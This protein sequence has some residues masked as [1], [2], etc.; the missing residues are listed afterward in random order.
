[1][2][3]WPPTS[4]AANSTTAVSLMMSPHLTRFLRRLTEAAVH[5]LDEVVRRPESARGAVAALVVADRPR[6]LEL[7]ER[8]PLLDRIEKAVPEDGVHV[9]VL[10]DIRF[11]SEVAVPRNHVRAALLFLRRH[12]QVG[13]PVQRVDDP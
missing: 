3:D 9:A 4:I 6:R 8:H 10:D 12:R 7:V 5:R 13:D 11:I 1:M 2:S